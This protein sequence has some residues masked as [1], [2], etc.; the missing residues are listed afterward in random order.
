MP[1]MKRAPA[2]LRTANFETHSH[3]DE[4]ALENP[5]NGKLSM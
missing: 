2:G 1:K 4:N 3:F 5:A